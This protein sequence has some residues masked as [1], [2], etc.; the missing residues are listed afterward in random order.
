MRDARHGV[1]NVRGDSGEMTRI[2]GRP[3]LHRPTPEAPWVKVCGV[4]TFA[5]LEACARAGATHVGI[6]AWPGSARFVPPLAMARLIGAARLMRLSPVVVHL[7]GSPVRLEEAAR[8]GA[9]FIQVLAP[10]QPLIRRRLA[11]TGTAVVEARRATSSNV[12]CLS[13]GDVLLLDA[14]A[15]DRFGGTGSAVPASLA[16]AA[17]RPF[18]LAGG[19]KPDN[20]AEAIG[21]CKPAGVDAS[22]GLESRPGQKD[23]HK[24]RDFC[25]AAREA[26]GRVRSGK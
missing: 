26:L 21:A 6:N 19:L 20:V 10:P 11:A 14:C 24:V 23:P 12:A 7:P 1:G 25:Q 18:V 13:W 3:H 8:M 17:P 16:V 9:A 15:G 2:E 5:D 4:R 22:S